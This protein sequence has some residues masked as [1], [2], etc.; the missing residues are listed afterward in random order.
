MIIG[1][2]GNMGSGKSLA[3]SLLEQM[4]AAVIKADNVGHEVLLPQGAAYDKV[5]ELFGEG[6]L[7]DAG[8]LD[9][10]RLGAFVF[11]DDSGER[12]RQLEGITHPAIVDEISRRIEDYERQGY[13]LIVVE[14][15]LFFGT[16]LEAM[17]DEIWAVV[18]PRDVLLKRIMTRDGC[19][20][21]TAENRLAKQLPTEEIARR[22]QR[23]LVNDG[24][25]EQL[26][27]AIR[28]IL[29][30]LHLAD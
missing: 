6:F 25:P 13:R 4:G 22:S 18:A 20:R 11:A 10:R 5:L 17:A 15:A 21:Q 26:A 14:A 8:L 19:D 2:T 3:S 12:L 27:A 9:R 7:D 28:Q 16:P 30:E 24:T 1:L 23:V 29:C